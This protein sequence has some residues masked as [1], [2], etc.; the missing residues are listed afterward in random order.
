M[1]LSLWAG[2]AVGALLVIVRAEAADLG[3]KTL[4]PLLQ[5]EAIP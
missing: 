4:I 1:R 3:T 2:A 5:E